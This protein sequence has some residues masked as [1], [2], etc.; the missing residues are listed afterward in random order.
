M[1]VETISSLD[2][3]LEL[4]GDIA[5][6]N[7]KKISTNVNTQTTLSDYYGVDRYNGVPASGTLSFDDFRGTSMH[8]ASFI[9][10]YRVNRNDTYDQSEANIQADGP[11]E[12]TSSRKM[13]AIGFGAGASNFIHPESGTTDLGPGSFGSID[14]D[15]GLFPGNSIATL[16]GFWVYHQNHFDGSTSNPG[17]YNLVIQQSGIV[18]NSNQH[19]FTR[20]NIKVSNGSGGFTYSG[21]F[22]R[23][24]ATE[25]TTIPGTTATQARAWVWQDEDNT[26]FDVDGQDT[27]DEPSALHLQ[28]NIAR[29]NNRRV[30]IQFS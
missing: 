21:Q 2:I 9:P 30:F 1:G 26:G 24:E 23:S 3:N 20:V 28:L 10:S 15:S 6:L 16:L 29:I 19:G 7:R 8:T 5:Y 22:N 18:T 27:T 14:Y 25:F 17:V 4:H 13:Y 12:T 11:D